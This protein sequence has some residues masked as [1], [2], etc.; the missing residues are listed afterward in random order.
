MEKQKVYGKLC[1]VL[2]AKEELKISFPAAH[3]TS[4]FHSGK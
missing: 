4:H 2:T 3:V 1:K